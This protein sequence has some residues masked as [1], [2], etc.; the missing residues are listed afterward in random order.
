MT[1]L[2]LQFVK[3]ANKNGDKYSA[4]ADGVEIEVVKLF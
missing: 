4:T 1:L 3:A 2:R